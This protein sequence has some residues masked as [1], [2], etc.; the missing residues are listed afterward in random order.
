MLAG[1]ALGAI[2]M[3]LGCAAAQPLSRSELTAALD[4]LI[5]NSP[6]SRRTC[7][8]LKVVDLQTGA[9]LYDRHGDWLMTPASNLKMY[10]TACALATW[11][12]EHRFTTTILL[13][14]ALRDG[15]LRGNVLIRGGG[16]P[17]LNSADL[18]RLAQQLVQR[19]GLREVQGSVRVDNSRYSSPPKG[20]GWMWDDEPHYFNPTITPLMVDENVL[21]VRVTPSDSD[22][23]QVQLDPASDYP[24]IHILADESCDALQIT[25]RA[26]EHAIQVSGLE[27]VQQLSEEQ[28]TMLEPGTWIAG[29]F[30]HMLS[31]QGVHFSTS[32]PANDSPSGDC[33][34]GTLVHQ[35]KT[36]REILK[37]FNKESVNAMGEVLLHEIAIAR[38]KSHPSWPDGA[39][40]I[41]DWLIEDAGLVE[42]SFR[43]DDGSGLSRYNLISAD[44]STRLAAFMHTNERADTFL[45]VLPTYD[46]ELS[47]WDRPLDADAGSARVHAKSGY[48]SG[49]L[50][51]SG[52]VR[53]LDDRSLAFSYLTA[54]FIGT[55]QPQRD[56]RQ[57]IW[58]ALVRYR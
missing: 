11:P 32:P 6:I 49:I 27:H 24:P 58:E 48:M 50:T 41:T 39:S 35:G 15:Q 1:S 5:D 26:F 8:C 13:A 22:V 57:Q 21:T 25:R 2:G 33:N 18:K 20:P 31:E 47:T 36:L 30:H 54:G 12:P 19:Y 37:Y 10:T 29:M 51:S 46:V 14:G 4:Q 34:A 42:G 53:T 52:F 7:V 45:A 55:S 44:S 43:L 28:L 40:A 3:G 23:P 16:D 17:M 38:G 56:L 9:S